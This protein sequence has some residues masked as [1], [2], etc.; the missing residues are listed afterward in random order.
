MTVRSRGSRE[1]RRDAA[2]GGVAPALA[3]RVATIPSGASW[4]FEPK[5]DGHRVLAYK[6]GDRA[7]L[8]SRNDLPLEPLEH[9]ERAIGVLRCAT[10][11]LDGELCAVDAFGRTDFGQLALAR[12]GEGDSQLVYFVFDL[13]LLDGV[14][15]RRQPLAA[16]RVA[17]ERLVKNER[18]GPLR[19]SLR[20]PSGDAAMRAAMEAGLEGV[21]AKRE[22]RAYRSGRSLDWVKVKLLEEA[23]FV[24]I[25]V[26]APKGARAGVGALL[27]GI[28]EQ[29]RGALRYAGKVGSGM[30]RQA[31]QL[32]ARHATELA[33]DTAAV[34]DPPSERDVTWVRPEL[35]VQVR[36]TE[37]TRDGHLRHPVY[38]GLREDKSARGVVRERA[39]PS[40]RRQ[41]TP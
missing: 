11:V 36:F 16:R 18:R 8:R 17:L 21:I 20:W 28:R 12:R 31:L 29:R 19:R 23:E 5:Y 32:L 34:T 37:W 22:D 3:T 4:V 10:A 9:I 25:G 38:L 35:V 13:L 2:P 6:N 41:R 7:D 40:A 14:D 24:L 30:D 26:T 15:L 33:T 1:A 39:R 27:L